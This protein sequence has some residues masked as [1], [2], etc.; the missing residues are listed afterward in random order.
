MTNVILK[1]NLSI[2]LIGSFICVLV[3]VKVQG[4]VISSYSASLSQTSYGDVLNLT[5]VEGK[6]KTS[7]GLNQSC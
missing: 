3:V 4:Q 7:V 1:L 5:N 6:S 2:Q